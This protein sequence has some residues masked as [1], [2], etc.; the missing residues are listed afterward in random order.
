MTNLAEPT[1]IEPGKA[2]TQHY[3]KGIWNLPKDELLRFLEKD[4]T[5]KVEGGWTRLTLDEVPEDGVEIIEQWKNQNPE[6][7]GSMEVIIKPTRSGLTAEE[8][9]ENRKILLSELP[10]DRPRVA[11][12]RVTALED[13]LHCNEEPEEWKPRRLSAHLKWWKKGLEEAEALNQRNAKELQRKNEHDKKHQNIGK[14]ERTH[15]IPLNELIDR[16]DLQL[17]KK[18]G[19]KQTL[20]T[21]KISL[22]NDWKKEESRKLI[23]PDGTI[24]EMEDENACIRWRHPDG[25]LGKPA[26][27]NGFRQRLARIRKARSKDQS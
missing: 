5:S 10:C 11:K 27:W 12:A 9:E 16:Y 15:K 6:V 14:G 25:K 20:T 21:V 1:E 4:L 8:E 2:T 26:D 19:R 13:R 17:E 22:K 18:F 23:D 24:V 3:G 7:L